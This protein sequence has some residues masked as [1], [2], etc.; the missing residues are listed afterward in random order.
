M[1]C[2][3][4]ANWLDFKKNTH[5]SDDSNREHSDKIARLKV[6]FRQLKTIVLVRRFDFQVDQV[7]Q[8]N[9]EL[10]ACRR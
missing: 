10:T 4:T 3:I 5:D 7:W 8:T 1:Y 9:N 2:N 6:I